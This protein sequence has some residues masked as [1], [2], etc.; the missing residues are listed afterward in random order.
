MTLDMA[1]SILLTIAI[2]AVGLIVKRLYHTIDT[3]TS[4]H[5]AEI[6]EL[7]EQVHAIALNYQ[8]KYDARDHQV[9]IMN[10]LKD[11]GQKLDKLNDKIEQKADK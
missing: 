7:Q 1:F 3:L 6:K 9:Q 10:S 8:T 11:L 5:D 4:K 2:S